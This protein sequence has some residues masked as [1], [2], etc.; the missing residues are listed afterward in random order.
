[1]TCRI[2][3]NVLFAVML[4]FVALSGCST[5]GYLRTAD[6]S[7]SPAKTS[8]AEIKIYSLSEIGKPY[9]T[10]GAVVASADGGDDATDAVNELRKQA[11]QL[12]A[13]AIVGLRL[14]VSYGYWNSAVRAT[15]LAVRY[16]D[17]QQ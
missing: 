15:G 12:G 14:E 11:G 3:S 16:G 2:N 6:S 4:S 13:D 1:M 10:I 5:S 8:P 7:R 9:E 17:T